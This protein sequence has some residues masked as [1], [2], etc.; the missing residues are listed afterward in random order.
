M[1]QSLAT[2]DEG[3]RQPCFTK[4]AEE[5]TSFTP[6]RHSPDWILASQNFLFRGAINGSP[7]YRI[8][9][10]VVFW[11]LD[12]H[13]RRWT[14]VDEMSHCPMLRCLHA[15]EEPQLLRRKRQSRLMHDRL[16]S[17]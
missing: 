13:S 14:A 15:F 8:L 11:T 2:E 5:P 9:H 17:V 10:L 7:C 6:V 16:G 4:S 3:V 12:D 1:A